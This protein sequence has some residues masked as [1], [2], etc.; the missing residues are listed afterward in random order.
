MNQVVA[1]TG[2]HLMVKSYREFY[3]EIN[4]ARKAPYEVYH[5]TYS[6]AVQHATDYATK[7]GYDVDDEEIW[8]N[9][10]NGPRKPS[11]G[12][13]NKFSLN[14]TKNGKE[15]RQRLHL[16]VHNKDNKIYE[17]NVYIS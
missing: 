6:G 11:S 7:R 17:L 1:N 2:L 10:S 16:Q 5:T 3:Q 4:E 8:H 15:V 14:L 12:K 13:T 9:I